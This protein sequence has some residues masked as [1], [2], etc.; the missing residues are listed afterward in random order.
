MAHLKRAA[1]SVFPSLQ[2]VFVAMRRNI[3]QLP[4]MVDYVADLGADNLT[5]QYVVVH[6]EEL[7]QESLFYHQ[8]LAN[9]CLDL[10]QERASVRGLEVSLPP[11]FGTRTAGAPAARRCTDPW[12]I[13]FINWKGK[14]R[15]CCYAP[16]DVVMGSLAEQS[17][18]ENLERPRLPEPAPD[19]E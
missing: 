12:K 6:G 2:V 15:P 1:G 8:D 3:E 10:A 5:V 14:V 11:H 4:R 18:W 16:S 19:R 9:R 13:A 7:R 17:F